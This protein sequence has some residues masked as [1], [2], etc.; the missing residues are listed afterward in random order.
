MIEGS[1]KDQRMKNEL[2]RK[3]E[4]TLKQSKN[5]IHADLNHPATATIH[6]ND[7]MTNDLM[8]Q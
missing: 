7:P 1:S 6:P 4:A 2:N 8:T 5:N 3:I